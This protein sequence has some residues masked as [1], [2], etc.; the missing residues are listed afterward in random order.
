M[1][2]SSEGDEVDTG[3][4]TVKARLQLIKEK[5]REE[6]EGNKHPARTTLEHRQQCLVFL[7]PCIYIEE[8]E[9]CGEGM[10]EVWRWE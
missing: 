6:H 2:G 9:G 10:I 5:W 8:R 4:D 1:P 7:P 3:M